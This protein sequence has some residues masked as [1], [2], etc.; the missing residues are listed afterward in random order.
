MKLYIKS[1]E[2]LKQL[3]NGG[4]K[5]INRFDVYENVVHPCKD[6]KWKFSL[7]GFR[8]LSFPL[9]S[10]LGYSMSCNGCCHDHILCDD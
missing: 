2:D 3:S 8:Y 6:V 5:L 1:E 7:G 4:K 9:S 10:S